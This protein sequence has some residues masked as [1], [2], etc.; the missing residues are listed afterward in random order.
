MNYLQTLKKLLLDFKL[1]IWTFK[2]FYII[3]IWVLATLF[4]SLEPFFAAKWIWYIEQYFKTWVL[5]KNTLYIFF[6]IWVGFIILNALL[7]FYHRFSLVDVS[8][9]KYYVEKSIHYKDKILNITQR[10]YLEKKWWTYYKII[11][12]WVESIFMTIFIFFLEISVSII[13][14]LFISVIIAFINIKL[15]LATL[16]VV[17]IFIIMWYYFNWKTRESQEII[18][19]KWGIADIY[20][21]FMINISRLLVLFVWIFLIKS[22]EITFATLFL[23][24]SYIGYIYFPISYIF[25]SL[26]NLQKQLESIKKLYEEFDK[27]PQDE[28]IKWAQD[29][30]KIIWKIEFKNVGFCF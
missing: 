30:E 27:I 16:A 4:A 18:H 2:F 25:G 9:L 17:P 15:A 11:D 26:K 8:A 10:V 14:V 13:S 12:R 28:D 22:W 21:H 23:F 20:T 29:I 7:R 24:F 1:F 3:I 19:K 6:A 5:D